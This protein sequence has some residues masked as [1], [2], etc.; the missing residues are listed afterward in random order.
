MKQG[1]IRQILYNMYVN[2]RVQACSTVLSCRHIPYSLIF[3]LKRFKRFKRSWFIE[4]ICKKNKQA[5]LFLG[6]HEPLNNKKRLKPTTS[7]FQ[8]LSCSK[9]KISKSLN[10]QIFGMKVSKYRSPY[11]SVNVSKISDWPRPFLQT[12]NYFVQEAAFLNVSKNIIKYLQ[13]KER[14]Q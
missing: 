9:N 6:N 11:I 2:M 7:T 4:C 3:K 10:S 12:V 14:S 13:Q 1:N 8:N 5:I